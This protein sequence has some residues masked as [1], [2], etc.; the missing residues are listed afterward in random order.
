MYFFDTQCRPSY[1]RKA[2][3]C[4]AS[5]M[6]HEKLVTLFN[7]TVHFNTLSGSVSKSE[8]QTHL[9][10]SLAHK[11]SIAQLDIHV[12]TTIAAVNSGTAKVYCCRTTAVQLSKVVRQMP[13]YTYM[14][15][16]LCMCQK[17]WKLAGSRQ[18][19]CKN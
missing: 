11:P 17:L 6:L 16:R 15:R 19:Y 7:T 10:P 5:N 14:Q 18:S 13:Y 3:S 1:K 2:I 8:N 4:S 12:P 9:C